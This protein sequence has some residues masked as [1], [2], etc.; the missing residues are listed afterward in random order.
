MLGLERACRR[1]EERGH[2]ITSI[3]DNLSEVLAVG[4]GRSSDRE[5]KAVLRRAAGELELGDMVWKRRH[6]QGIGTPLFSIRALL[7]SASQPRGN[8]CILGALPDD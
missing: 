1:E 8:A 2:V 3:S 4:D 7:I 6:L 5:L